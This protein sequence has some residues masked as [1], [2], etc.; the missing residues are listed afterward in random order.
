MIM[1]DR[2]ACR[3]VVAYMQDLPRSVRVLFIYSLF[4]ICVSWYC[5][6]CTGLIYFLLC[7]FILYSCYVIFGVSA[8]VALFL[9]HV[10]IV[11]HGQ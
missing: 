7:V 3:G 10:T 9:M 5:V 11:S 2:M 6:L 8:A 4:P 1:R